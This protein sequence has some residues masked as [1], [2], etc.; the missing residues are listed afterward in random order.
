MQ[1]FIIMWTYLDEVGEDG[2]HIEIQAENT[3]EAEKK[4]YQHNQPYILGYENGEPIINPQGGF[5]CECVLTYAEW[6]SEGCPKSLLWRDRD[7]WRK[8]IWKF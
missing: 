5:T 2:G 1:N 7:T 4:F 6:H 3:D 8:D